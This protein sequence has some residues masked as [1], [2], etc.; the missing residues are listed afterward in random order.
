M[1]QDKN[2]LSEKE[3]E[4]VITLIKEGEIIPKE[5]LY[6]MAKDDEDVFLF[7]NGRNEEVTNVVLPFHS[8]EHID[9]PR[10]EIETLSLLDL[11][12]RGRQQ[13][14]WTNKLIWGDNKLVL[15][16]L[17]NGPLRE[18]IEKEGGIK[19]IYIDPPLLLALIS[20]LILKLMEMKLPRSRA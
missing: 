17:V 14:G 6:K 7:W 5:L 9:E 11:D 15:S 12:D 13:K 4:Q 18:E 2:N 1:L 16:S 20:P 19:L 8:I 3:K 10:K